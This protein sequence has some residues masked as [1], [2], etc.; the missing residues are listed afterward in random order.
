MDHAGSSLFELGVEIVRKAL[1]MPCST[2][3]KNAGKEGSVIVERVLA[4]PFE[5]GYDA[6]RDEFVDMIKSGIID[7][8][9]VM[10]R[11]DDQTYRMMLGLA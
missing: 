11:I 1:R 6:H 7:P 4:S 5:I 9:K 10:S 3:S 2:I 8:T